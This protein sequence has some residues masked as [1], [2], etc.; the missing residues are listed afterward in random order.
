MP[1]PVV[2]MSDNQQE[3]RA[4]AHVIGQ[5]RSHWPQA[6]IIRALTDDHRDYGPL[7]LAA[8]TAALNPATKYPAG[9]RTTY[10]GQAECERCNTA[11]SQPAAYQPVGHCR[12]CNRI[13]C[14]CDIAT[15]ERVRQ[16]LSEAGR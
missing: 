3:I 1:F 8:I 10:G 7:A 2:P 12:H 9:I 13:T 5:L 4:L 11:T 16:I 14:V 15:P 6:D